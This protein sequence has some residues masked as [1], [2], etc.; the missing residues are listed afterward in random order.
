[1]ALAITLVRFDALG[2]AWALRF[3]I[4]VFHSVGVLARARAS[5]MEL[6]CGTVDLI[7]KPA[8]VSIFQA[9]VVLPPPVAPV[10]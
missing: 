1:M 6:Y 10:E 5:D 4:R 7:K 9:P 3:L 8:L 2:T